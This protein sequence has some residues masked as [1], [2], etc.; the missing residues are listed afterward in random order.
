MTMSRLLALTAAFLLLVIAAPGGAHAQ[1]ASESFYKGR[2]ID[3]IISSGPG[4]TYDAYARALARHM[5]KHIPGNPQIIPKQMEGAGGLTAANWLYAQAPKNGTTIAIFFNPIPFLPLLGEKNARYDAQRLNWIGSAASEVALLISTRESQ[6]ET[7]D[8]A[9]TKGMTVGVTG[10]GSGSYFN[11]NLINQFVG[12]KLKLVTG[13]QTSGHS[14]LAME[15]GEV[16]GFPGIMLATLAFSK[17]EWIRDKRVNVLLQLALDRHPDLPDVPTIFERLKD[18]KSKGAVELALAPLR[19]ARPI[20]APPDVPADRVA[21]LRE[22][23]AATIRDSEFQA[24]LKKSRLDTFGW[25]SGEELTTFIA[26]MYNSPPDD[27]EAV[28]A[29]VKQ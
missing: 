25:M 1:E 23:F 27:V 22:A 3:F 17:P 21:M 20:A 15:R 11:A 24:D 29:I 10:A 2:T 28:A 9:I 8:D 26:R 12:T 13:Y 5:G 14:L 4:A 16:D 6:V 7:V 19:A 18:G